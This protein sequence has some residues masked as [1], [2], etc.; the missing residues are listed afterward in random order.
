MLTSQQTTEPLA[1]I[2]VDGAGAHRDE[3]PA[4]PPTACEVAHDPDF[5][6]ALIAE[7]Q[8]E[9]ARARV[10]LRELE[11]LAKEAET[12]PQVSLRD[13]EAFTPAEKFRAAMIGRA[14][15]ARA[16]EAKL[17][18]TQ[19]SLETAARGEKMAAD[20][21]HEL[22]ACVRQFIRPEL[23]EQKRGWVLTAI[24]EEEM[25][26]RFAEGHRLVR[27]LTEARDALDAL[28]RANQG[29][30]KERDAA[31]AEREAAQEALVARSKAVIAEEFVEALDAGIRAEL[32]DRFPDDLSARLAE[33]FALRAKERDQD[34]T[35][36][37][38]AVEDRDA[39]KSRI[40][41]LEASLAD[42][43]RRN[44]DLGRALAA[45][46]HVLGEMRETARR[47]ERAIVHQAL[48]L[49]EADGSARAFARGVAMR[50]AGGLAA[51]G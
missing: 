9:L 26:L 30:R 16:L 25:R 27:E 1:A 29:L 43:E 21:W 22:I 14:D 34:R 48:A 19:Q 11:D 37:A 28:D 4:S 12:L 2:G 44:R 7:T 38:M 23:F 36:V 32:R 51:Q 3:S 31:V 20:G 24:L 35:T 49:C 50:H 18:E 45:E 10:R 15:G 42:F 33:E 17:A 39:A 5:H 41:A 47:L 6:A 46:R 13:E 40:A 8:S